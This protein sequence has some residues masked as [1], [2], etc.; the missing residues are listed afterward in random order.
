M[1]AIR[2]KTGLIQKAIL[3][4][5]ASVVAFWYRGILD[6]PLVFDSVMQLGGHFFSAQRDFVCTPFHR[7]LSDLSFIAVH[8]AFGSDFAWQFACNL[9]L[10]VANSLLVWRLIRDIARRLGVLGGWLLFEAALFGAAIFA[11]NPVAVYGVAYLVQR[12]ILLAL[13]FSLLALIFFVAALER[14]GKRVYAATLVFYLL[15][16]NAKEQALP[17]PALAL[18]L[19]VAAHRGASAR[20]FLRGKGMLIAAFVLVAICSLAGYVHFVGNIFGRVYEPA[21]AGVLQLASDQR[22]VFPRHDLWLFSAVNQCELFF[23]YAFLWLAPATGAMAIE[24]HLPFPTTLLSLTGTF[25]PEVFALWGVCAFALAR[26]K[27]H[28]ALVGIALAAPWF[29]FMGEFSTV[30]LTETFV[31]YRA[32]LWEFLWGLLVPVAFASAAG[33]GWRRGA[34]WFLRAALVGFVVVL[35]L[36][37]RE[38]LATFDSDVAVWEDAV[39][40]IPKNADA[41]A[42]FKLYRTYNNYGFALSRAGHYEVAAEAFK[43]SIA[44]DP[45]Y[46]QAYF[47][48]GSAYANTGKLLEAKAMFEQALALSPNFSA[49]MVGL[50]N[51]YAKAGRY[52]EALK[53]YYERALAIDPRNADALYNSGNAWYFL[54]DLGKAAAFYERAT[55]ANPLHAKAYKNLAIVLEKLGRREEAQIAWDTAKKLGMPLVSPTVPAQPATTGGR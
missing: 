9:L 30:R 14:P 42:K 32:Y 48:L 40:K 23:R 10:H 3:V 15:A 54:N 31:L 43:K 37:T 33:F 53:S 21:A 18:T 41:T 49:A 47:N 1:K 28:V 52:G 24:T 16:L 35:A 46:D 11:F 44:L 45:N 6:N 27:T 39:R 4:M 51:I 29:M 26:K 12:S 19:A 7:C 22:L 20:E 5:F 50:G 36:A 34:V 25:A 13:F 8:R 2:D 38:R 17:L 55:L